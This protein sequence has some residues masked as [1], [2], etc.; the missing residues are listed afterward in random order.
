MLKKLL[1]LY[2]DGH[3]PFPNMKGHGGLGY[4]LPQYRLVGGM[5]H[6]GVEEHKGSD[7]EDEEDYEENEESDVDEEEEDDDFILEIPFQYEDPRETFGPNAHGPD[8]EAYK[9]EYDKYIK[10]MEDETGQQISSDYYDEEAINDTIKNVINLLKDENITRY[11]KLE[12]YQKDVIDNYLKKNLTIEYIKNKFRELGIKVGTG[13]LD[14]FKGRFIDILSDKKN[15]DSKKLMRLII[16][17]IKENHSNVM[18]KA[19][20]L[21]I[22]AEK[23]KL[24]EIKRKEKEELKGVEK[25]KKPH[26]NEGEILDEK[27]TDLPK[28]EGL[29]K[30]N[31]NDP[32]MQDVIDEGFNNL[33]PNKDKLY[34]I[35]D[36]ETKQEFTRL[37]TAPYKLKTTPYTQ[38]D[39]EIVM[40]TV[41]GKE[42]E[43]NLF[44]SGKDFEVMLLSNESLLNKV[45]QDLYGDKFRLVKEPIGVMLDNETPKKEYKFSTFDAY[46]CVLS[47]GK[48]EMTVFIELKKYDNSFKMDKQLNILKNDYTAYQATQL[49]ENPEIEKIDK[50]IE[51]YSKINSKGKYD[52]KIKLL[53]E[54]KKQKIKQF[55]K[56]IDQSTNRDFSLKTSAVVPMKF[57]KTPI[58][59]DEDQSELTPE[60]IRGIEHLK[61]LQSNPNR[62]SDKTKTSLETALEGNNDII[63]IVLTDKGLLATTYKQYQAKFGNQ[64]HI[65]NNARIVKGPYEPSPKEGKYVVDHIGLALHNMNIIDTTG[66]KRIK[67]KIYNEIIENRRLEALAERDEKSIKR[68]PINEADK[69]TPEQY[70]I[71]LSGDIGEKYIKKLSVEEGSKLDHMSN[72]YEIWTSGRI[73]KKYLTSLKKVSKKK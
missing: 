7:E 30:V 39:G 4:H 16:I 25:V 18:Q 8:F 56:P 9:K 44:E 22:K 68:T 63:Y 57:T 20:E 37:F 13:N 28:Y 36:K 2:N 60:H 58:Y 17:D 53:Q 5:V 12:D 6:G 52:A 34:N 49:N 15:S 55:M 43:V 46:R 3:N 47:N 21:R 50:N 38:D 27:Y 23:Q 29:D 45:I 61:K 66:V 35:K 48:D 65:M 54:D 51:K 70:N 31:L 19:E 33:V 71:W 41:N 40:K 42:Q 10:L 69:L 14:H 24:K 64:S 1:Y 59:K 67:S 11:T 73:G 72:A 62:V 32:I 26:I